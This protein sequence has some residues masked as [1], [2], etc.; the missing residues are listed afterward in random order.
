[1]R[2]KRILS[3]MEARF[4]PEPNG[5]YRFFDSSEHPPAISSVRS[6]PQGSFS[7]PHNLWKT[8]WKAAGG[9]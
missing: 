2:S 1:V 4:R 5:D 9:L 6:I 3:L 8:L 7:V